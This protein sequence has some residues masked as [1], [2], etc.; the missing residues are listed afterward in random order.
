MDILTWKFQVTFVS[1]IAEQCFSI[2]F[3]LFIIKCGNITAVEASLIKPATLSDIKSTHKN[4]KFYKL[5]SN[6]GTDYNGI[7]FFL[8]FKFYQTKK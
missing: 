1:N 5:D 7:S 6:E 8:D 3:L 2:M 4:V